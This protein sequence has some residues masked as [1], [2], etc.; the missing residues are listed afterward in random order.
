MCSALLRV[1]SRDCYGMRVCNRREQFPT[2]NNKHGK[3]KFL[4]VGQTWWTWHFEA[5]R[6]H[7]QFGWWWMSLPGDC[8]TCMCLE[9]RD[10]Q[11][12]P[13]RSRPWGCIFSF[14]VGVK[15]ELKGPHVR[16]SGDC[17]PSYWEPQLHLQVW[18]KTSKTNGIWLGSRCFKRASRYPQHWR[19]QWPY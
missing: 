16:S 7:R 3:V 14:Y 13:T 18:I 8:H 10:G 1:R 15:L 11:T 5:F 17:N 19:E 4:F 2:N 9:P 12:M 6:R